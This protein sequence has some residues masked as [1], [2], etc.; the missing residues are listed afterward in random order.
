MHISETNSNRKFDAENH[1]FAYQP[2][3]CGIGAARYIVLWGQLGMTGIYASIT[4]VWGNVMYS[5]K[6]Y[7]ID[8]EGTG[9]STPACAYLHDKDRVI[10]SYVIK[11]T[12]VAEAGMYLRAR[13]YSGFETNEA[14]DHF[15]PRGDYYP[16]ADNQ[17]QPYETSFSAYTK[18]TVHGVQNIVPSLIACGNGFAISWVTN[19][20]VFVQSYGIL[21]ER[22]IFDSFDV[23]LSWARVI[24][25]K[26]DHQGYLIPSALVDL[27][28]SP[29]PVGMCY[30]R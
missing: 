1:E 14:F 19:F 24:D 5:K 25:A 23:E 30:T 8:S 6:P 3:I 7:K 4:D 15:I 29:P 17:F 11:E 22:I 28:Q 12:G 16:M 21:E 26:R 10:I 13:M 2:N 20:G 18:R 27:S 9:S